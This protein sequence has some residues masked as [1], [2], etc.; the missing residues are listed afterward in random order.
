MRNGTKK[1]KQFD[2]IAKSIILS[3]LD[4]GVFNRVFNCENAHELWKTIKEQ[5]EGSK[6]VANECYSCLLE[7]INSF[8]QLANENAESMYSRLNVLVNEINALCVKNITNLNINLK[9]LQCLRKPDYDLVKAI[10]YEK[11]L[12]ELKPSHILSK[13]MAHELQIMPKSKK[14]PQEKPQEPSSQTTSH[15]LSSQQEKVLSRMATHGSSG[16]DD[17]DDGDDEDSSSD[18]EVESMVAE[19]VK[20]IFKYVKKVNMYGY[21]VHLREGRLL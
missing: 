16:K 7:E 2:V 5:N 10:I 13:I 11:K 20:K 8:K 9:I 15:A 6:E 18:E 12:K 21:N 14:A 3:S 4:V 19:Y 1:E 17:G